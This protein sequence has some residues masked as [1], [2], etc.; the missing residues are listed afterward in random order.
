MKGVMRF[1][2]KGK[3]SPRYI[4]PF[5]VLERVGEMAY[6]V[7]LPPS[8]SR[9]YLVFYVSMLISIMGSKVEVEEYRINEGSLERKGH[10]YMIAEAVRMVADTKMRTVECSYAIVGAKEFPQKQSH[11]CGLVSV[12]AACQGTKLFPH[13]R[14]IFCR[15]SIIDA[16]QWIGCTI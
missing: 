15:C 7:A 6:K 12:E 10:R 13:L 1:E 3:V 4:G 9:V 5:K 11:G 14:W 2:K 8:L 16:I